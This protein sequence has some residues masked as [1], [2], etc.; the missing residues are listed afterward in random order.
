VE[1]EDNPGHNRKRNGDPDK[2]EPDDCDAV[3]P[4]ALPGIAPQ[5]DLL[6]VLPV[7]LLE[8]DG[9]GRHQLSRTRGSITV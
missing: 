4:E 8:G 6:G 9:R 2:G 7:D 1:D 5:P 3:A